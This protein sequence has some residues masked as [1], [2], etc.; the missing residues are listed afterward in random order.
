VKRSWLLVVL[1]AFLFLWEPLRVAGELTQALPTMGMRGW[2]AGVELLAHA[3]VAAIAAAAAW[4]LWNGASHGPGLA[5]VAL[6]LSAAVTIQSLYWSRLPRQT[7]PG[8]QLPLAVL[9]VAHAGA[10]IGYL[11]FRLKAE[12]ARIR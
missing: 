8:A 3:S 10:W 11:V 1:S 12:A 7:P 6:S 5:I 9:A 2:L 4:S